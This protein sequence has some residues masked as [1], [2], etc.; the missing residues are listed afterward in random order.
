[1]AKHDPSWVIQ[2][3]RSSP[4]ERRGKLSGAEDSVDRGTEA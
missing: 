1:M 4:G 2:A 3:E